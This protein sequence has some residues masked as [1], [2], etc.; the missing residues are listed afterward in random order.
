MTITVTIAP[1]AAEHRP[2][3]YTATRSPLLDIAQAMSDAC[4]GLPIRVLDGSGHLA[5][6]IGD[7]SE[8]DSGDVELF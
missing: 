1:C 8:E 6:V 3:V 4:D 7:A 5:A 2:K